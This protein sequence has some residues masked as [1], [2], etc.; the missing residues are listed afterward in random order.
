MKLI[1]SLLI[2]ACS[3]LIGA[4]LLANALAASPKA[5]SANAPE[6]SPQTAT[7]SLTQ[8]PICDPKLCFSA[9]DFRQNSFPASII[10]VKGVS[11]PE[12]WGTWSQSKTVSIEFRD[13]LPKKVKVQ[14]VALAYKDNIGKSFVARIDNSKVPFVLSGSYSKVEFVLDNSAASKIIN[15]DVP[16][17]Q[18]PKSVGMGSDV[19]DL[20]INL[21]WLVVTAM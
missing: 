6:A 4:G 8:M 16:T 13:N 21:V 7:S 5:T 9:I 20:G 19:R 18:S 10:K 3:C 1:N 14:L 12:P 2:I 11:F 15:I 17:P